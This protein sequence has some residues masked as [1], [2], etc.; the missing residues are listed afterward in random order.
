MIVI[1][2]R[3]QTPVCAQRGG[4]WLLPNLMLGYGHGGFRCLVPCNLDGGSVWP[5]LKLVGFYLW[6]ASPG[7]EHR[8]GY[9]P[10]F[11]CWNRGLEQD[12]IGRAKKLLQHAL[13]RG[14]NV[15]MYCEP[16]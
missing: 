15:A 1:S 4:L 9:L 3:D 10:V 7:C 16:H 6:K 14:H 11:Q 2:V 5:A 8:H 12:G 13:D